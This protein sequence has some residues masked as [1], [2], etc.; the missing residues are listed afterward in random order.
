MYAEGKS[1]PHPKHTWTVVV[2]SYRNDLVCPF[3]KNTFK[4][5]GMSGTDDWKTKHAQQTIGMPAIWV[6]KSAKHRSLVIPILRDLLTHKPQ[7]NFN[8]FHRYRD[9]R[10]EITARKSRSTFITNEMS[11]LIGLTTFFHGSFPFCLKDIVE[12]LIF[13][14]QNFAHI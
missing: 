13:L 1:L 11:L 7:Y 4:T 3:S 2:E 10:T 12:N 8:I 6:A 14:R 9:F 5:F